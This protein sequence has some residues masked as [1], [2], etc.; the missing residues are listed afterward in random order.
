[1]DTSKIINPEAK[2]FI[3]AFFANRAI[4]REYYELVLEEQY[5]YRMVD[6]AE[7]KSDSP[8][9]SLAHQAI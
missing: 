7:R 6:T 3:N 4:N 5:D 8:E 9:E 1:M 2:R